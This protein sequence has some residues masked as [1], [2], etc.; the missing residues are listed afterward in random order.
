NYWNVFS[1][2]L[3]PCFEPVLKLLETMYPNGK[4]LAMELY[5]VNGFV[6]HH[7]TDI[8]GDCGLQD[9]Y[10]PATTWMLGAAWI[11]LFIFDLYS[12]TQDVIVLK[13]YGYL[14]EESALF[15]LNVSIRDKNNH[16]ILCPSLS[17]EN[18][19]YHEGIKHHLALGSVMDDEI[20]FDVFSKTIQMNR[21]LNQHEDINQRLED[22]IKDLY[23]FAKSQ[24][25]TL[26]EWHEDYEEAEPG[27]RHI[28]H[29]YG[30]YPSNQ[31]L[32]ETEEFYLAKQ[33]LKRRLENGGGHTGWSMAWITAMYARLKETESAYLCFK[34]F[35]QHSTSRVG[36]DLHP[37]F[38][39]DG[40]FG[41]AAA[42]KE[43]F[44]Y[45]E[46]GILEIFPA[47]PKEIKC[48]QFSNIL[49]RGNLY[50][51]LDYQFGKLKYWIEASR[52]M[53]LK[54]KLFEKLQIV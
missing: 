38:Q 11:S 16:L 13:R 35:M 33:T 26:R 50:L 34:N 42:I 10:L 29:L 30:L 2:N 3:V 28:S 49:L 48:L 7:N 39:I 31:I 21:I 15:L 25:G 40:N 41:I 20:L 37:P 27:H 9:H 8:Y 51:S 12:Y 17:P 45:D 23:S 14:L 5:H 47:K 19:F 44:V 36:L 22:A 32:P 24:Y 18:S 54:I 4:L 43:M 1:A 46:E 53:E 6:A 52:S